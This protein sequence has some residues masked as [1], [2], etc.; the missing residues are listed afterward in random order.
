M[1]RTGLWK[2][3]SIYGVNGKLLEAVQSFY[4]ESSACVR[5]G[6]VK[7]VWFLV[8]DG[9]R[10]GCVMSPWLF[11]VYMDGVVREVERRAG[12]S[13]LKLKCD[14]VDYYLQQL[15]YADDTVFLSE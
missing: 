7:S 14:G 1:N 8:N 4:R 9:L 2:V 10:Q 3:L 12:M 13:G 6:N 5:I 15:L 11:N